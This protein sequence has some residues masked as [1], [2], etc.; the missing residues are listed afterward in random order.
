MGEEVKL[1]G[2]FTGVL[3]VPGGLAGSW[4]A[5]RGGVTQ[6]GSLYSELNYHWSSGWAGLR[7]RRRR[8][9]NFY[10]LMLRPS[11]FSFSVSA[12]VLEA[13][14]ELLLAMWG[15]L[16]LR[17]ARSG[18]PNGEGWLARE[19][20]MKAAFVEGLGHITPSQDHTPSLAFE[21][22]MK[23]M[24]CPAELPIRRQQP[25]KGSSHGVAKS[26]VARRGDVAAEGEAGCWIIRPGKGI[27]Q[28]LYGGEVLQIS[29]VQV[30]Q[31]QTGK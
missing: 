1:E 13:W 9:P 18:H 6:A 29:V 22:K 10:W 25:P 5:W 12:I 7:G 11:S 28:L 26:L 8:K 17:Q 14:D 24:R 4:L 3:L 19:D 27:D 23:S 15:R 16:L 21:V 2:C 30:L 20:P 31:V